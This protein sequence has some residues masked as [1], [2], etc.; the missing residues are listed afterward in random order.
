[1]AP[2]SELRQERPGTLPAD[3]GEWDHGEPPETLPADFEFFDVSSCAEGMGREVK[4]AE[5][6]AEEPTDAEVTRGGADQQS[7]GVPG[8]SAAEQVKN[9]APEEPLKLFSAIGRG[10]RWWWR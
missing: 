4:R 1:M 6:G 8:V 2:G 3:F 5:S 10:R 9:D 7:R